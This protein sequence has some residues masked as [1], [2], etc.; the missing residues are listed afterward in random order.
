MGTVFF[1]LTEDE[2]KKH[3][4]TRF[5]IWTLENHDFIA[6]H[7]RVY[8]WAAVCVLI[9]LCL[10]GVITAHEVAMSAFA[11][12]ALCLG[13]LYVLI[14]RRRTALRGIADQE[15]KARAHAAMLYLIYR[16]GGW[17]K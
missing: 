2:L 11:G 6:G 1:K 16:R 3:I 12:G 8:V 7:V 10:G 4:A 15:L 14:E 5:W 9:L 13:L 17:K